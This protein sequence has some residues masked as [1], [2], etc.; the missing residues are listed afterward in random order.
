MYCIEWDA[1]LLTNNHFSPFCFFKNWTS[2]LSDGLH[3]SK[4][5]NHFVAKQVIPILEAKL[6]KLPQVFPDW[7]EI[8]HKTPENTF[9]N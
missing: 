8:D 4:E 3:L 7:K 1:V 5:G 9:C 2:F 6:A